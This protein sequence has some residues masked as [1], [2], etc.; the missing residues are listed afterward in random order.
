MQDVEDAGASSG[1]DVGGS[2]AACGEAEGADDESPAMDSERESRRLRQNREAAK[3]FRQKKKN[4]M[5]VRAVCCAGISR[6][7]DLEIG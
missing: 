4:L 2:Y 3:R 6:M 5:N 7:G 1:N